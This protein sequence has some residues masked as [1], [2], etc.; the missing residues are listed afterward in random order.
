MGKYP[1]RKPARLTEKLVHI[2]TALGLSQNGLV[3]HLGLANELGRETI[4][5]YELGTIEPPLS[6]LLAYARAVNVYVDAL[7]DDQLDLPLKLPSIRKSEGIK[8]VPASRSRKT[9]GHR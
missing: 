4:S 2:R 3:R 9:V 8:R 5:G 6:V 7:I 1:R